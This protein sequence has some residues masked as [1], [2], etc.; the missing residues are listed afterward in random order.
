MSPFEVK[1]LKD[2]LIAEVTQIELKDCNLFK[3][4]NGAWLARNNAGTAI[5][6]ECGNVIELYQKV[7]ES[8]KK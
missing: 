8:R 3:T 7:L 5:T 6:E 2:Q 4:S 1:R